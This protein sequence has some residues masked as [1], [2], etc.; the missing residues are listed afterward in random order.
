[1]PSAIYRCT[2]TAHQTVRD[3]RMRRWLLLKV[4]T[5]ALVLVLSTLWDRGERRSR[6]TTESRMLW[7]EAAH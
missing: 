1:M 6:T 2:G 4:C 3:R 5:T 7:L